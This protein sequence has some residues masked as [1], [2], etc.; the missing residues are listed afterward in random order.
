M[1]GDR[2]PGPPG[3]GQQRGGRRDGPSAGGGRGDRRPREWEPP[4]PQ[5][6]RSK[7][8]GG[9]FREAQNALRDARKTLDKRKAEFADEPQWLLE[10]YAEAEARFTA[11]ATAWQDHL[12]ATG[13]RVVRG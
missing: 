9:L 1:R 5:D 6:E 12:A 11:A 10:A 8:L 2:P 3:G 4:V 13:R 7:E